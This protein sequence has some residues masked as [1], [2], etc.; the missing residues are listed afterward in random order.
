MSQLT[1][2]NADKV[3]E[4]LIV[5]A[6]LV[7][8][9]EVRWLAQQGITHIISAAGELDDAPMV[10]ASG[11]GIKTYHLDWADNG[12]EKPPSDFIGALI[13]FLQAELQAVTSGKQVGLYIHCA[14]GVNRGPTLATF[15]LAALSGLPADTAWATIQGARPQ[16][17]GFNV[18]AYRQSVLSALEALR[19][20]R[21]TPLPAYSAPTADQATAAAPA[22][23]GAAA[24][25][26]VSDGSTSGGAAAPVQADAQA[27]AEPA[28]AEPAAAEPAK[29]K[30]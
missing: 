1:P 19:P 5:G 10:A 12:L 22:G 18:P 3:T 14:A 7:G 23:A 13:W 15:F 20:F 28:A 16:A 11:T 26:G 9:D 4:R 21:P 24:S 6:G 2:F 29:A 30:R 17:N 27:A 8:V 25:S